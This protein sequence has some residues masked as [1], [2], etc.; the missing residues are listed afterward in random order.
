MINARGL[1]AINVNRVLRQLREDGFV[2]VKDGRV[3]F[4]DHKR[5]AELAE[6]D[7]SYLDQSGPLLT[8]RTPSISLSKS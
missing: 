3:T 5:L 8:C 2:T 6:F 7:E 4:H 1:S